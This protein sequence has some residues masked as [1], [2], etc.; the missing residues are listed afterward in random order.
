[1]PKPPPRRAAAARLCLVRSAAT[2]G[3]AKPCW[4]G[5]AQTIQP[6]YL[7]KSKQ[8]AGPHGTLST[9]CVEEKH[10]DRRSQSQPPKKQA[11]VHNK[12]S[13]PAEVTRK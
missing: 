9:S 3:R 12:L 6:I 1:M 2:W 5:P 13:T 10:D 8:N 7:S 4:Y 11:T